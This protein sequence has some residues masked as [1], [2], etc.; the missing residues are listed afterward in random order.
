MLYI[1]LYII[2]YSAILFMGTVIDWLK[3]M[4]YEI[5]H[6]NNLSANLNLNADVISFGIWCSPNYYISL[7]TAFVYLSLFPGT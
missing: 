4:K 3:R 1:Y 2:C 7:C 5:F 6:L